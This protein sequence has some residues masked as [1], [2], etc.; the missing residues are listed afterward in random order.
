M[1]VVSKNERDTDKLIKSLKEEDE[2]YI[3]TSEGDIKNYLG[4]DIVKNKDGYFEFKQPHL[5][6]RVLDYVKIEKGDNRA[7]PTP[8]TPPL[9]HKD[10]NGKP[11]RY[12]WNYRAV[13]GMLNFL[14]GSTRPGINMAVHQKSRFNNNPTWQ[15]EK[16]VMRICRY[17][18]GTKDKGMVFRTETSKCLELFV[19]VD[20]AG[21]WQ[22]E[23]EAHPDNCLSS[24]GFIIRFNGC[25]II[26]KFHLQTEIT[27]S[28]AEA[29]C[30]GFNQALR[31]MIPI[32]SLL[33]EFQ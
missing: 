15:H 18:E 12:E 7:K 22:N 30:V 3:L 19:N 25:K 26:W 21:N 1:I 13:K 28:T 20:F 29:E 14:T 8:G 23:S 5:I 24:T 27:L 16:A 17:L 2:R 31:S 4:V 6:Q 10:I 33:K 32:I 9:L 11:K